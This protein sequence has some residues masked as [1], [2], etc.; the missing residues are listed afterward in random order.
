MAKKVRPIKKFVS[1]NLS[2]AILKTVEDVANSGYDLTEIVE[3]V[4]KEKI[5]I[6]AN[7]KI[8]SIRLR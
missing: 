6:P 3:A 1:N 2:D 8:C 5:D 7:K 4:D